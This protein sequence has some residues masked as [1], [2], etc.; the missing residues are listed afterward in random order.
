[1]LFGCINDAFALCKMLKSK[2]IVRY[3]LVNQR[4]INDVLM[5]TQF[6]VKIKYA[7]AVSKF[8]KWQIIVRFILTSEGFIKI[9]MITFD[10]KTTI[11]DTRNLIYA[12]EQIFNIKGTWVFV[13]HLMVLHFM[14]GH[15]MKLDKV[16]NLVIKSKTKFTVSW[17]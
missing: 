15:S 13:W 8:W 3:V 14:T 1:M 17:K 12:I 6:N 2:Q 10:R 5:W 9:K 7:L 11:F 4:F 16:K